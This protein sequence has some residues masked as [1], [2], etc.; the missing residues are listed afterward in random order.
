M[1]TL[2]TGYLGSTVL[3][4]AWVFAGLAIIVVGTRYYVRLKVINKFG[5]DDVLIFIALVS[6]NFYI[7]Q[8]TK[9]G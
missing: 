4:I 8:N 9:S 5:T 6:E 3:A 1:A 2:N 7:S